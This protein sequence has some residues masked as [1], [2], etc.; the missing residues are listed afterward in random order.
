MIIEIEHIKN[1]SF[2]IKINNEIK[3]KA[4]KSWLNEDVSSL[5]YII[6]TKDDKLLYYVEKPKINHFTL[7]D[8]NNNIT[9]KIDKETIDIANNLYNCYEK[10]TGVVNNICIY[11]VEKQIAQVII[12]L[13]NSNIYVFL[14]DEYQ[15][16]DSVISLYSILCYC[17]SLWDTIGDASSYPDVGVRYTYDKNTNKY[18]DKNW[19][20]NNFD[21]NQ[22]E[23]IYNKIN[24]NRKMAKKAYSQNAK[25]I[26]LFVALGW[27]LVLI[28][29][30]IV[31]FS[32]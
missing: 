15:N 12:P 28:I 2:N 8:T 26:L 3:Y 1:N 18:Y 7:K 32:K 30:I 16:L 29:A 4:G 31:Y 27:V 5:N 20:L 22:L 13:T 10:A 9:S 14:L 21:N 6:T 23:N 24:N 19:L 25:K 17:F 11:D